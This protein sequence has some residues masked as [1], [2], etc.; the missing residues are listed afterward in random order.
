MSVLISTAVPQAKTYVLLL[1]TCREYCGNTKTVAPLRFPIAFLLVSLSPAEVFVFVFPAD[2][3]WFNE[4]MARPPSQHMPALSS[5]PTLNS[6]YSDP[7]AQ[8]VPTEHQLITC[9][10]SKKGRKEK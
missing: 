8:L 3:L 1:W 5:L 6:G 10:T 2:L 4:D 9:H 7:C